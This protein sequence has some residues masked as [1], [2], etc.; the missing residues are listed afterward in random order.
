MP[1]IR[2]E[3]RDRGWCT[4][5]YCSSAGSLE[6]IGRG[7]SP[8][9]RTLLCFDFVL[10]LR[11]DLFGYDT[12]SYFEVFRRID[13]AEVTSEKITQRHAGTKKCHTTVSHEMVSGC[14]TKK[15]NFCWIPNVTSNGFLTL[16][17]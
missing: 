12:E 10:L 17:E 14:R 13:V 9:V 8:T 6:F 16:H 15:G 7:I 5:A 1:S 3:S 11:S 2:I 4:R